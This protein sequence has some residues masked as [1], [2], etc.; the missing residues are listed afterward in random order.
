MPTN[1]NIESN[2]KLSWNHTQNED[3]VKQ[4]KKRIE[5]VDF[6]WVSQ[7][8]DLLEDKFKHAIL[9]KDIGCQ[10]FQFYKEIKKRNLN[11]Q[12]FGYELDK[13]YVDIG[14][15]Y[16]P[17]LKDFVEVC[18]FSTKEDVKHTDITICSATIEHVDNWASFLMKMLS[19]TTSTLLLRTFFG[20]V[21]RRD[22]C[23]H[24]GADEGYPIWQFS[25][26]EFLSLIRDAGFYPE[27]I[28]DRYTDSLPKYLNVQPHGIVRTQYVIVATREIRK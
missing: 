6:V 23:H 13:R 17:E 18:D 20:E 15:N 16:F 5:D 14:L 21:T 8:I 28:K 24:L 25:F 11:F 22:L 27:I 2:R 1:N 9:I 10:A 3:Y 4:L 19:T 7:F 12:Y 26:S